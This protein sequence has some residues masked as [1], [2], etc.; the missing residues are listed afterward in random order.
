MASPVQK[1]IFPYILEYFLLGFTVIGLE[2]KSLEYD[3]YSKLLLSFNASYW[4]Y[5][6]ILSIIGF[7]FVFFF[8]VFMKFGKEK[9]KKILI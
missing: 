1:E 6:K 8:C 3:F 9:L 4:E 2:K 7:T 5:I